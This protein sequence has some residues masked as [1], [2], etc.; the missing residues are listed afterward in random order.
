MPLEDAQIKMLA[1]DMLKNPSERDKQSLIG[2]SEIGNSCDYCIGNRLLKVPKAKSLYW[3]GAKIG[4]AI[5]NELEVEGKKHVV[6]PANYR[7][8]AL[9]GASIEEKYPLGTIEGYGTVKLKPDLVLVKYHHL[10]DWK[11]SSAKKV[12][13]YKL[14]GLP[15]QYVYQQQLYAWGLNKNGVKIERCSLVFI[16]REGTTDK[17]IWVSSFDY[18]ESLALK[19]WD[20]LELIWT[21]LQSGNDVETLESAPD[22]YYCQQVLHRM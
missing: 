6:T 17:D 3:L 7:F 8:E 15:M 2:P 20:R 13:K 19:A 18:D 21:Y 5:H 22:C 12:T 10:V 16:N 14:D 4:T 11:T 1:L 9:E